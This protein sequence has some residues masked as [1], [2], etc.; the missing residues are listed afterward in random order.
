MI[1]E[2]E[3]LCVKL[4]FS[5]VA[6]ITLMLFLCDE[7]IVLTSVCASFLH[8]SGHLF[9]LTLF[10]CTPVT[11]ILSAFG[12]RIERPSHSPLSFKKEIA[13]ALGGII[14]NIIGALL[15]ALCG[16]VLKNRGFQLLVAVNLLVAVINALPNINLDAGRAFYY[17]LLGF[18]E[19]EKAERLMNV[20]SVVFALLSV[21]FFVFYTVFSA[22]NISL[23]VVTVYILILTFKRE[24]DK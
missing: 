2:T 24:V 11:V 12:M 5:F 8:E 10:R 13:V 14:F 16:T 20:L 22:L 15:F 9:F 23:A 4:N 3:K 21:V 6:T 18:T 17:F 19:E 7:R 1:A